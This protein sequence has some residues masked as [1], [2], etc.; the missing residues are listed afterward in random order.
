MRVVLL[1]H[2]VT[3]GIRQARFG[4][5]DAPTPAGLRDA[6]SVLPPR[7]DL[8]LSAPSRA[9]RLTAAAIGASGSANGTDL[10]IDDRLTGCD[11]GRWD[12][13][14]LDEVGADE[15]DALAE[16][17]ADPEAA[18][19]GGESQAALTTRIGR[20]LDAQHGTAD[21]VL[22][23]A[24]AAVIRAAVVYAIGAGPRALW[25]I[26]VAPLSRVLLVGEPGRWSLRELGR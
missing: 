13:R 17:L 12:G 25:R 19:H 24:D 18:P 20:W 23:V 8:L 7:A 22:A 14:S 9:C 11:Y 15:P 2:A 16:W 3:E 6:G 4:G 5:D 26:D 21:A 1:C 10:V